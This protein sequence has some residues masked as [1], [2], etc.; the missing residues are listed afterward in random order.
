MTDSSDNVA[1]I[2]KRYTLTTFTPS[3]YYVSLAISIGVVCLMVYISSLYY[4]KTDKNLVYAIPLT[5]VALTITQLID[6]KILKTEYSK[7]LHMSAFGNLLWLVTVLGGMLSMYV[8]S[9]PQLAYLYITEGMFLF[10]SFRIGIF[11]STIGAKVKTAWAICLIQ[12]LAI[13]FAFVPYHLWTPMLADVKSL[14]FGIAFLLL[15]TAWTILS[16]RATGKLSRTHK[17]LQAYVAA[18]TRN[19]PAQMETIIEERSEESTVST[20]QIVFRAKNNECRLVLPDVHPG[21]FH[22]IGGSNI[23]YLIYKNLNF[24]AMVMHSVSDH[25]LNLPSKSQVDLYLSSLQKSSAIQQGVKCTK[26]VSVQV[27]R[28]RA[29]GMLFDKNAV[30][31]LS[32]S[33]HG[34]EDIPSYVKTELEQYGKNRGFERVLIVDSHNAMGEIIQE[35]DADD[36]LKAAKSNLDTLMTKEKMGLE[37]GYS[38]SESLKIST[39]DL[40]PG[41]IAV[42]CL[43]IGDE[44]FYLGWADSNN[45]QN[46]LREHIANHLS[47]NGYNLLEVCTSDTHY[48]AREARNKHGYFEF[49]SLAKFDDISAWF[50]QLASEAER[51]LS[52]SS[53]ELLEQETRVKV[54]GDKQFEDYSKSLDRA[55]RIT[56]GFLIGTTTLFLYTLL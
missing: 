39:D 19:D 26:P 12:P 32:L 28:A 42:V 2:H 53:F 14:T 17:M 1:R 3:S 16:D 35:N 45:M 50:L 31:I 55:M 41:K 30:L 46:G 56:Q 24:S 6:R 22:P 44:K 52:P 29:V 25:S 27:N 11:T 48:K 33:P 36:L 51:N 38:N 18:S 9:K 15:G 8:F 37:V 49:G 5:V 23:T 13:F 54:M 4:F 10:A 40:G 47:K 34:M 20:F 7:S 43:K 21:P